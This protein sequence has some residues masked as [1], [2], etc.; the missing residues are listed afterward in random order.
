MTLVPKSKSENGSNQASNHANLEERRLVHRG[1][2]K[3][4]RLS[5]LLAVWDDEDV[6]QGRVRGGGGQAQR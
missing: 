3:S 1:N 4:G 6:F 2:G 5:T